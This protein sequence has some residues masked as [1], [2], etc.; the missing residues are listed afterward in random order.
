M[1]VHNDD[2][3]DPAT[4]THPL[5]THVHSDGNVGFG[6][7][8]NAALDHVAT[9]RLVLVNPDAELT[10]DH[11]Q[12]LAGGSEDDVVSVPVVDQTGAPTAVASPYP[13]PWTLVLTGW[14]VG[15]WLGRTSRLRRTVRAPNADVG[16]WPLA[17]RWVS[18]A[19]LSVD[20]ERFRAV[21]GF[22]DRYF[23]YM[24]DVDL[25]ARLAERFPAMR[26]VVADVAPAV[27]AVSASSAG[28]RR[29]QTDLHYARSTRRYAA[30]QRGVGWRVARLAVGPRIW[31]LGR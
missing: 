6:A 11:W 5:V 30:E 17:E 12:A 28:G 15:R 24:E 21:G 9:E 16:T 20:T 25:C 29:R 2:T 7:A 3:L 10:A 1:V 19:A 13:T 8:I 23:L 22:D 4:V 31:W 27:H 26:A 14:R 18:A